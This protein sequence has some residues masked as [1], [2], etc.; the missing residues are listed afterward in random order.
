MTTK[1]RVVTMVTMVTLGGFSRL[2]IVNY[3]RRGRAVKAR[4]EGF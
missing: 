3:R 1:V 2:H 4:L